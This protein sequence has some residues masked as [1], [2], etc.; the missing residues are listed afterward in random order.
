MSEKPQLIKLV[1]LSNIPDEKD[2]EAAQRLRDYADMMEAGE[3]SNASFLVELKSGDTLT[4]TTFE[5]RTK[6]L[7]ALTLQTLNVF[8]E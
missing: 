4:Y 1:D 6:M 2:F 7:G 8:K 3:I 5:D